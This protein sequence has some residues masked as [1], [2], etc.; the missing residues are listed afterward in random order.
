MLE[1]FTGRNERQYA[2]KLQSDNSNVYFGGVEYKLS[3][4]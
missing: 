1:N 3:I 2:V 4:A